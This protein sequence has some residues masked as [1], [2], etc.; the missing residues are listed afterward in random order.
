MAGGGGASALALLLAAC[1]DSDGDG[2]T[3]A[4][5][6][7]SSASTGSTN[8][9]RPTAD[10][11][12][13]LKILAYALTLE[14]IEAAFYERVMA[15]GKITDKAQ[16]TLLRTISAHE[17]EHVTALTAA[18]KERGGTP[19][20]APRTDFSAV[21]DGGAEMIISTAAVVE[22][23]GASAYLG[24]AGALK[25]LELLSAALSIHTVEARHAAALN[26]I[27]GNG[28]TNAKPLTG[29]LPDGAFAKPMTMAAVLQQ[30]KPFLA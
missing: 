14:H 11:A 15:S 12:A 1:G 19:A 17:R 4:P 10:Q 6:T 25:S 9:A 13:D 2:G 20:A 5:S 23:L 29:S 7:P 22:N 30:V 16:V 28:F 3:A 18:I 26:A 8:A 21:I 24:Q 27:A